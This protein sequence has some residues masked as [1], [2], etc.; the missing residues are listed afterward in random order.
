[1]WFTINFSSHKPVYKQIIEN[2][3]LQIM[4][5]KL[6]KGDFL[7][8]IRKMAEMLDV[9]LNTVS[10][11]YRELVSEGIIEPIRGEGYIVKKDILDNFNEELI[12][13]LT[14]IVKKCINAGMKVD[15]ICNIIKSAGGITNAT[16]SRKS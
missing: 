7:P 16:K 9:N 10:R 1:M 13:E 4:N 2:I 3:K 11:A 14:I 8:S 12:N 5:K 6:K 15:D